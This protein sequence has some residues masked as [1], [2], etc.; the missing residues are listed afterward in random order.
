MAGEQGLR[1]V[2]VDEDEVEA[3]DRL[4]LGNILEEGEVPGDG[5]ALESPFID[6]PAPE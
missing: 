4:R 6:E 5:A 2:I 3:F 1:C